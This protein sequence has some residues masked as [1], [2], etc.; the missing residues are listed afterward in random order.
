VLQWVAAVDDDGEVVGAAI[1]GLAKIARRPDYL[2]T[3]AVFALMA[4]TAEPLRREAAIKA[5]SEL[6]TRRIGDVARGLD[7]SSPDVRCASVE[8]LGRMQHPNASRALESALDDAH[9]AVRL[10]AIRALKNLGT[11]EPLRKLMTLTRTDPEAE[12]RRAA[13]FAA[14]RSDEGVPDLPSSR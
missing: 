12:V 10:A 13:M 14:S 1:E 7:D 6:P 5:L 2:G 9:P 4:L 8:A 11:R 3:E